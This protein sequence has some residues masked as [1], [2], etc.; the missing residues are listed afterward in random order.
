MAQGDVLGYRKQ[1]GI[2]VPSTNTVVQPDCDDLRP[3]GVTNHIGRIPTLER[4][5]GTLQ[6]YEQHMQLMRDGIGGAMDLVMSAK[7]D[8]M[9]MGVALEAFQGGIAA[10]NKLQKDLEERA[11]V[12]VSMGAPATVAA[13]KA[14]GVRTISI[15]TPHQP[16]GDETV[17]EY[18]EEAGFRIAKLIGLKCESP[19]AIARVTGEQLGETFRELDGP[20][21]E[22]IVQVGTNLSGVRVAANAEFWLK[23]PVLA[24]NA[25]TYWDALRRCGI[26]DRVYG[27]GRILEE[28]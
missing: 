10:S 4:G 5:L 16:K 17:R 15:V 3:R 7:V 18:M 8:H 28:F 24:T 26:E 23:K 6:T 19:L 9:I 27:F 13:L 22:A 12:G 14:F 25:V 21:V 2:V 11:G 20:E 1:I